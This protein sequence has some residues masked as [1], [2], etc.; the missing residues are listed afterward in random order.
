MASNESE[1]G[2]YTR[3]EK[4]NMQPELTEF[5]KVDDVFAIT[6]II[7]TFETVGFCS[8]RVQ[9][10]SIEILVFHIHKEFRKSG[11]G[12]QCC[13]ELIEKLKDMYPRLRRVTLY[14]DPMAIGFWEKQGFKIVKYDIDGSAFM[15]MR[16]GS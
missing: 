3:K 14:A 11:Y 4:A 8:F 5:K 6:F 10:N 7:P 12:S 1:F 16:L 15:K 2:F 13:K 9:S